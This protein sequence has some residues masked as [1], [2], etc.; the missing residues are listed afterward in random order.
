MDS[1]A[2]IWSWVERGGSA[3]DDG[4]S[5]V[6]TDANGNLY[7]TGLFQDTL[8]VGNVNL[9]SAGS[10]DVYL[11]KYDSAGNVIWAISEGGA[12]FDMGTQL[13]LDNNG[14]IYLTGGF[15]ADITIGNSS[16]LSNG[17][18]NM[19]I[20]KY[21][22][23]GGLLWARNGGGVDYA[24]SG[25]LTIDANNDV[26][27][28]G[29]FHNTATFGSLSLNGP[30]GNDLFIVKYEGSSGNELWG[31]YMGGA[32]YEYGYGIEV[33]SLGH[34]YVAGAFRDTSF[35]GSQMLVSAGE[36]D[37]YVAK[38][39]NLGNLVWIQQIGGVGFDYVLNLQM[40]AAENLYVTGL[41]E[42]QAD[43]TSS[44]SLTSNG[45]SDMFVAKFDEQ[46]GL[47]WANH[48]GG[49]DND[50]GYDL[51]LNSE[52]EVFVVGKMENVA[53]FGNGVSVTGYGNADV[54]VTKYD[55][56]GNIVWAMNAGSAGSESAEGIVITP[57]DKIFVTGG[58]R[59]SATFGPYVVN[60]GGEADIFIGRVVDNNQQM[61]SL[62]IAGTIYQDD[63]TNCSQ[64]T[65]ELGIRNWIVQATPGPYYGVTDGNGY[66]SI[67]VD[68]GAYTVEQVVPQ[69]QSA[70]VSNLCPAGGAHNVILD[71]STPDTSGIDFANSTV[72]CPSLVV[73]VGSSRRR[74]CFRNSTAVNYCNN[75]FADAPDARLYV[76]FPDYVIPIS[77]DR[78]YIDQG[79][80]WIFDLDTVE[81]GE[82]GTINIIDSVECGNIE[83]FGL[84][85]CTEAWISPAYDC[86]PPPSGW[87][88]AE[89]DIVGY[90]FDDLVRFVITNVGTADMQ[91]SSAF[92][93]FFDSTLVY[94]NYVYLGVGDSTILEVPATGYT[95]RVEVEQ[96][97]NHPANT[98]V[99]STVEGCGNQTSQLSRGYVNQFSSAAPQ[100]AYAIDCM[101]IT[102]SYDPNDK[103]AIP[104]GLSSEHYILPETPI[105]YTIR[106]QNTGTDTAFQVVLVDTLSEHLD[107]STFE[108]LM[109]SHP[110]SM[111]VSGF[112][113]PILTFTF[114]NIMLPDS[115]TNEPA[116][117]GFVKFRITPVAP[118]GTRIENVADIYFD[119]NPAVRTNY[120]FHT[121]SDTVF[122][123]LDPSAVS[124]VDDALPV[125][126]IGLAGRASGDRIL[127]TWATANEQNSDFFMVEK[128]MDR[129]FYESIGTV[130][131]AGHSTE[132]KHYDFIDRNPVVGSNFY[133]LKQYDLDGSF[134]YSPTVEVFWSA[135]TQFEV[136]PNPATDRLHVKV[137]GATLEPTSFRLMNGVGAVVIQELWDIEGNADQIIDV[138]ELPA[139]T[140]FYQI[141]N[142]EFVM[143]KEL[144]IY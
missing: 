4:A 51:A 41:M 142:G 117:N 8:T 53:S 61:G 123:D 130:Q 70:L 1:Q 10:F 128:S 16:Y 103:R 76:S 21:D 14:N 42:G 92:D 19:F 106:F 93:V 100:T 109:A 137:I 85:Q 110:V 67:S 71:G 114:D 124:I 79:S 36:Y 30:G 138:S 37:G 132:V 17:G 104:E 81:A 120:A 11:V 116:S 96:V 113:K 44:A 108:Y 34:I 54:L 9:V 40:D 38:L 28:T 52:G 97:D 143:T 15:I 66:F 32:N 43:F 73:N 69:Q 50:A 56:S 131:A 134:T 12:N 118:L 48:G 3:L 31:T 105:E 27:V 133:R 39:D 46:G 65:G 87:S 5:D 91:D 33:N 63:N 7:V 6:I 111:N 78:P 129:S 141:Q 95:V 49:I 13:A 101:P 94:Q 115:N 35:F 86:L 20:A 62:E 29:Q 136:Y 88:G 82:C 144:V 107:I 22:S 140:Y 45:G 23:N 24:T 59:G 90:C 26:Y 80:V 119:A 83:I 99:S 121:L 112:G 139:G 102:A 68:P 127:L 57:E 18:W 60:T 58:L 84:T 125:E 64:E 55:E 122:I 75:G 98:W 135:I 126:W 74:W 72:D 77:A 47:I 2:Q 89:L 25:A